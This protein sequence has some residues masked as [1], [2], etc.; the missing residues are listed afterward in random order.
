MVLTTSGEVAL[1]MIYADRTEPKE[2]QELVQCKDTPG[3]LGQNLP[4]WMGN[5]LTTRTLPCS[6]SDSH[7]SQHRTQLRADNKCLLEECTCMALDDALSLCSSEC[8]VSGPSPLGRVNGNASLNSLLTLECTVCQQGNRAPFHSLPLAS[9]NTGVFIS[10]C[11]L[12]KLPQTQWLQT[13]QVNF[14]R[15]WE[16]I[17]QKSVLL[18]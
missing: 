12:T 1:F 11:C 10:Y 8:W 6:A 13:A 2:I 5:S 3:L 17:S 16:N 9:F 15:V 7:Q 18:G 4:C 14:L